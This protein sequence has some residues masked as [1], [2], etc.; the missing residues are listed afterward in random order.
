MT[1]IRTT[2][3]ASGVVYGKYWGGGSGWYD[4][5]DFTDYKSI[6]DLQ[7]A[8]QRALLDGGLDSGMGY[9]K[10]IGAKMTIIKEDR[11]SSDDGGWWVK[12][13]YQDF[14][15]G[16]WDEEAYLIA[17]GEIII[18]DEEADDGNE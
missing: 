8:I 4:A 9:E 15:V 7:T 2:Y 14:I 5:T 11:M 17:T 13:S 6:D 12:R 10:L 18:D 3:H 1:K 16:E